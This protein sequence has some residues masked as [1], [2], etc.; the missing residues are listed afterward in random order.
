MDETV[1]EIEIS[2]TTKIKAKALILTL[3]CQYGIDDENDING[4]EYKSNESKLVNKILTK[5]KNLTDAENFIEKCQESDSILSIRIK[6]MSSLE[7]EDSV[8]CD[9]SISI[10]NDD[11]M[12]R[13]INTQE[14]TKSLMID[15]K[16]P[17][18]SPQY[19]SCIFPND[20]NNKKI[21]KEA[22]DNR[23]DFSISPAVVDKD[24]LELIVLLI[25]NSNRT[26]GG[27]ILNDHYSVNE[28]KTSISVT[29]VNNESKKNIL[30]NRKFDFKN[31]SITAHE[32]F[33]EPQFEKH[34]NILIIYNIDITQDYDHTIVMIY[35]ENLVP[36]NPIKFLVTSKLFKN[37]HYVT[38]R[39]PYDFKNVL[40]RHQ[41]R[42]KIK[43]EKTE[44]LQA[45]IT[46]SVIGVLE[47]LSE[48]RNDILDF[49]FTNKN[50]SSVDKYVEIQARKPFTIIQFYN[51]Q[52]I[53]SVLA[54]THIFN[55]VNFIVENYYNPKLIDFYHDQVKLELEIKKKKIEQESLNKSENITKKEII[56]DTKTSPPTKDLEKSPVE[57]SKK[58][59]AKKELKNDSILIVDDDNT[60]HESV[61][62]DEFKYKF[63]SK[64]YPI[65][66]T[67]LQNNKQVLNDINRYLNGNNLNLNED[68]FELKYIKMNDSKSFEEFKSNCEKI[69]K[70]FCDVNE[71]YS[72][73]IE[74]SDDIIGGELEEIIQQTKNNSSYLKIDNNLIY[75]YGFKSNFEYLLEKIN[76]LMKSKIRPKK[77][78]VK[79]NFNVK[80]IPK[81]IIL[82]YFD[83]EFAAI[84]ELFKD[85]NSKCV[86]SLSKENFII[87]ID[88]E[89]D[90]EKSED[91]LLEEMKV[92]IENGLA[93]YEISQIEA[94]I[95]EV[96]SLSQKVIFDKI[97][98][99]LV[100]IYG[101]K[102]DVDEVLNS[103]KNKK[104][105]EEFVPEINNLSLFQIRMLYAIKYQTEME[106]LFKNSNLKVKIDIKKLRIEYKCDDKQSILEAMTKATE[107]FSK[108]VKKEFK[109]NPIQIEFMR[110]N[111][112]EVVKWILEKKLNAVF[113]INYANDAYLIYAIDSD[114]IQKC[115]NQ[116]ENDLCIKEV[117]MDNRK[118]EEKIHRFIA[119]ET[120]NL[121]WSGDK[122][123]LG[124]IS[125]VV[126]LSE[127]KNKLYSI[128]GF[129]SKVEIVYKR[130]LEYLKN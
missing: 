110:T 120:S 67:L 5:F 111:E 104:K 124:Y 109:C 87:E 85:Y 21:K 34:K 93:S 116:L 113:D 40:Q 58:T 32:P 69:L 35:A 99:N 19:Q 60:I 44:V 83:S 66:F 82:H 107:I 53:D 98:D 15:N 63:N 8:D 29:Y 2:S 81:L 49:H 118:I 106:K 114:I 102:N 65:L 18:N 79:F 74:I 126:E 52:Q 23:V 129:K 121:I 41:R 1:V 61:L 112:N 97:D 3:L 6:R 95:D 28:E 24:D 96:K 26:G 76:M 68:T 100:T 108:I 30:N 54:Q 57:S 72:N 92:V 86:K 101:K 12:F 22:N 33:D 105:V 90:E 50:K 59:M 130:L 13:K 117:Q 123:T 84:E 56:K 62:I 45:F 91:M 17:F 75:F 25:Q 38:F 47:D 115:Y 37:T 31:Y 14:E 36:N 103:I 55:K 128:S 11:K 70:N 7:L 51:Q 78:S 9:D 89:I 122:K 125:K 10:I 88:G 119:D 77:K 42:P 64:D 39:D 94:N 16:K 71:I 46:N 20:K 48:K 73:T 27:E 80:T 43:Q 4:I 127:N